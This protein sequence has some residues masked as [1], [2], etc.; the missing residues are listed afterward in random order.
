MGGEVAI[1]INTAAA[2]SH[3]VAMMGR[4]ECVSFDVKKATKRGEVLGYIVRYKAAR[5]DAWSIMTE[6]QATKVQ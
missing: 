1:F 6:K 4:L 3:G 2:L 5:G